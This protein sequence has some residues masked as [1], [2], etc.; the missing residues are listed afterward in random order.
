MRD[1]KGFIQAFA[2]VLAFFAGVFVLPMYLI[3]SWLGEWLFVYPLVVAVG[4]I[5]YGFTYEHR[6][7]K[8]NSWRIKE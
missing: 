3:E 5:I 8:K 7:Q 1:I 4:I 2:I 6:M